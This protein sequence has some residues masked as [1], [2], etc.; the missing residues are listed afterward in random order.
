MINPH[1]PPRT[2]L[3]ISDHAIQRVLERAPKRWRTRFADVEQHIRNVVKYAELHDL[4]KI[5]RDAHGT[6]VVYT[7]SDGDMIFVVTVPVR[8][9]NFTHPI[10]STAI[11]QKWKEGKR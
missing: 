6:N 10:L 1:V 9:G 3:Q 5:R 4:P 11:P 7:V 2:N 8:G